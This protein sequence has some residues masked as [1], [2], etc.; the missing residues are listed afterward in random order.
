MRRLQVAFYGCGA[1]AALIMGVVSV[2]DARLPWFIV[3]LFCG[4][5]VVDTLREKAVR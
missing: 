1:L 3:A 4:G 5:S 2:S